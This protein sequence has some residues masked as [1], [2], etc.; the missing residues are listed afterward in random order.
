MFPKDSLLSLLVARCNVVC[1]GDASGD[2]GTEKP[3]GVDPLCTLTVDV[4]GG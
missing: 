4:K 1:P 3:E 2:K